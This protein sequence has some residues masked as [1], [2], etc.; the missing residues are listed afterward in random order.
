MTVRACPR[1]ARG[2]ELEVV[3]TNFKRDFGWNYLGNLVGM[4]GLAFTP[5][6]PDVL[7]FA[8]AGAARRC[9][10]RVGGGAAGAR[11]CSCV[12]TTDGGGWPTG[13]ML[14]WRSFARA[15]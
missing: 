15:G 2:A 5:A 6:T 10:Q 14:R 3:L 13:H 8:G 12:R 7:R 9:E 1:A 4:G 11:P